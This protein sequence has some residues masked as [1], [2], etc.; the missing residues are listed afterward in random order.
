M[1]KWYS[2][3][4]EIILLYTY[5]IKWN[6]IDENPSYLIDKKNELCLSFF[7]WTEEKILKDRS[8]KEKKYI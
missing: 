8:Q 3:K 6:K 1:I 5:L 4:K 7:Y 2:T